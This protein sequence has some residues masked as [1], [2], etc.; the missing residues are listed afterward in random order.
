MSVKE[1]ADSPGPEMDKDL[2][3]CAGPRP[4]SSRVLS[5]QQ[6]GVGLYCLPCATE[7][8]QMQEPQSTLACV[9]PWI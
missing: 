2:R 4:I 1:A 7:V 6:L 9:R 3:R 5:S 8:R